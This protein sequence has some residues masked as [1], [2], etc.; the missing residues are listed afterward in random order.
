MRLASSP[1]DYMD[2]KRVV[3]ILPAFEKVTE[4]IWHGQAKP[5]NGKS[6]KAPPSDV[7][8]SSVGTDAAAGENVDGDDED[9]WSE[10]EAE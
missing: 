4:L 9:D 1:E 10:I 8:P 7:P 5:G 2:A 6:D 3:D